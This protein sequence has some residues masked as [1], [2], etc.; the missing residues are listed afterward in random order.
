MGA[1]SVEGF[2]NNKGFPMNCSR[3]QDSF[4]DYQDGTLPAGDATAL[5]THL[6]SC[7]RTDV[8]RRT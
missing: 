4:I 8:E 1:D 6:A 7:P 5:R 2:M 3:V